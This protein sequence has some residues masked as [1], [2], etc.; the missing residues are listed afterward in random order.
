MDAAVP[1]LQRLDVLDFARGWDSPVV[2]SPRASR[3]DWE[4]LDLPAGSVLFMTSGSTGRMSYVVQTAAGLMAAAQAAAAWLGLGKDDVFFCPL[5]M[6][7]VAGFGMWMRAKLCGARFVAS[8]GKWDASTFVRRLHAENATVVSL[9]PTQVHDIVQAGLACPQGLRLAVVGGGHLLAELESESRQLGWPVLGS[10]GMTETCGQIATE[11]PG[12]GGPGPCWLPVIDGWETRLQGDG[13]LQIRGPGLLAGRVAK[14]D[15]EWRYLRAQLKDGW[16]LTDDRAEIRKFGG[17]IWLRPLGRRDD[18]I[19]IRG[20]LVS[21]AAA[22]T[23]IESLARGIGLAPDSVAV[24]DIPNPRTGSRMVLVGEPETLD[25][26][27]TLMDLFNRRAP[28]F[29]RI[30]GSIVIEKIPRSALGKLR[31]STLRE[32]LGEE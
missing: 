9:V 3:P 19:K 28:A 17:K 5:P 12:L 30:E 1:C 20:E 31:R 16:F 25:R 13:S 24:I 15:G 2:M 29:A 11:R 26:L 21:L 14:M 4:K 18:A 22:T 32:L 8:T 10:F 27:A 23:E 6:C 7:H